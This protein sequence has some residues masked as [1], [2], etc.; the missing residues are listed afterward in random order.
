MNCEMG[1]FGLCERF[2]FDERSEGDFGQKCILLALLQ[3]SFCHGD[4][5]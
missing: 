5:G 3:P 4:D 2:V 1:R